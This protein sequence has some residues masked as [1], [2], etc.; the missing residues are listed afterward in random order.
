MDY[1]SI[2]RNTRDY[3]A[4]KKI[5]KIYQQM[6]S[7]T[8]F[9]SIATQD[10]TTKLYNMFLAY[11]CIDHIQQQDQQPQALCGNLLNKICRTI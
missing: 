7:K 2:F 1:N 6:Q 8:L 5:T 10:S 9:F 4:Y 3:I 11:N